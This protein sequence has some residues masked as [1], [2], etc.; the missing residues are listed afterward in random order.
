MTFKSN[1]LSGRGEERGLQM[2]TGGATPLSSDEALEARLIIS[3]EST[4]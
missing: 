1:Y 4:A 2:A 3:M